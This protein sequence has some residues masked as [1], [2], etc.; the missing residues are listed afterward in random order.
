MAELQP[1][2]PVRV[3]PPSCSLADVVGG[4]RPQPVG[5]MQGSLI[6]RTVAAGVGWQPHTHVAGLC[7]Q[8][9]ELTQCY[10]IRENNNSEPWIPRRLTLCQIRCAKQLPD[11]QSLNAANLR[12]EDSIA[13]F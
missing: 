1:L 10:Y 11:I 6:P 8:Y 3:E 7:F 9:P 13:A 12:G 2:L 4:G 5:Q